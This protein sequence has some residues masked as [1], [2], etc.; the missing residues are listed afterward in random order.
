MTPTEKR[1]AYLHHE[2]I[3]QSYRNFIPGRWVWIAAR[4]ADR[5]K[6]REDNAIQWMKGLLSPLRYLKFRRA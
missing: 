5:R 2:A 1:E 4:V 6:Q 3:R